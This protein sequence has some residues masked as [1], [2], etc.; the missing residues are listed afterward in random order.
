[1]QLSS[2]V[3]A[4][5]CTLYEGSIKFPTRKI[6]RDTVTVGRKIS[7]VVKSDIFSVETVLSRLINGKT[8][9]EQ[10]GLWEYRKG[11]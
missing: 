1:M 9:T 8:E 4:R 3:T 2:H 6:A 10:L 5:K 11:M 7:R